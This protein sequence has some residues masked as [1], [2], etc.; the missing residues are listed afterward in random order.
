MFGVLVYPLWNGLQASTK[1][2]RY[3]VFVGYRPRQLPTAVERPEFL[4]ALWITVRF[5]T[6]SVAIETFRLFAGAILREGVAGI[7]LARTV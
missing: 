7:R 4:D 5:V 6:V 1:F 2:Y 3:G